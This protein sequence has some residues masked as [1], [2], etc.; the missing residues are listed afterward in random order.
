MFAVHYL[1]RS[2]DKKYNFILFNIEYNVIVKQ[3]NYYL[4][5]TI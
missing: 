1:K 4:K 2:K 3:K 5:Y